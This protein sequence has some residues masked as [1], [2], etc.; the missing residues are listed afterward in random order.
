MSLRQAS[1]ELR[2]AT[3][4]QNLYDI[5]SQIAAWVAAQVMATGL[6]TLFVRHTTASLIVQENADPDVLADLMDAYARFAPQGAAYRHAAEG[7][8]DMPG[9]IKAALAP[10]SL[11]IPVQHGRPALGTWQ[12][13]YLAEWRDAPHTRTVALHFIGE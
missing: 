8:D 3:R 6:L 2:V 5:T 10:V 13:I 7:P 1:G 12:A 9:H 11:A 4:G